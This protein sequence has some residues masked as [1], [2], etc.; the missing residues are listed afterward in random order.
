M[1][2]QILCRLLKPV[3]CILVF[4]LIILVLKVTLI[5]YY[6]NLLKL[7]SWKILSRSF[8]RL[9][10]DSNPNILLLILDWALK[11][12][13]SLR[14]L[15]TILTTVYYLL[16]YYLIDYLKF[17]PLIQYKIIRVLVIILT[18]FLVFHNC[19]WLPR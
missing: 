7:T 6:S 13:S 3:Y 14:S 18:C 16:G 19:L 12:S 10:F 15:S 8:C 5:L 9:V 17:I 2:F 11:F 1:I 4:I